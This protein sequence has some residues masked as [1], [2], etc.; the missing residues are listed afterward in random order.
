MKYLTS[1]HFNKKSQTAHKIKSHQKKVA[2][3]S[4]DLSNSTFKTNYLL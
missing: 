2:V 4:N 1:E 3:M